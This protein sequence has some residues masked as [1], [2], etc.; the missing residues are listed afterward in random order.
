MR[1]RSTSG[2][3]AQ[4]AVTSGLQSGAVVLEV[5]Q[6]TDLVDLIMTAQAGDAAA[7]EVLVRRYQD[8]AYAVAFARVGDRQLAQDVAQEA[9]LQA[10]R[11]LQSLRE[12]RAFGA[13]LR[14]LIAKHSDRLL[15]GK[16][17][18]TVSLDAALDAR[19]DMPPPGDVVEATELA[20]VVRAEVNRL[21]ERERLAIALY[22]VADRPQSEIAAFLQVPTSTIKKRLHDARGRLKERLMG[23][24]GDY[25]RE[26]RPS[27]DDE[28]A[29]RV[30]FLIAVR[31]GDVVRVERQLASDPGLLEVTLSLED[32]GRAE[33]G[34]PTLPLEFDYTPLLFA[35]NYGHRELAEVLLRHGANPNAHLR[36]ETPLGRAVLMHDE[37]NRN[38]L[39]GA[40]TYEEWSVYTGPMQV[41]VHLHAELARLAPNARGVLTVEVPNGAHVADLLEQLALDTQRR[42]IV[43]VNGEAAGLDQE[44]IDGARIDLLTPMAGGLPA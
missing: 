22:Y 19:D 29:Q 16:H 37:V 30:N 7:F 32:W 14:R 27:Q 6:E 28:F 15:R 40:N 21:P 4:V 9:F 11:D 43:G 1:T 39:L 8:F 34:Q 24:F 36:G 35:A 3:R 17:P 38:D 2:G 41:E 23:Q 5:A 44:L 20:E 33:M 31:T 26:F 42:I 10:H 13:W 18:I 25:L 12:P